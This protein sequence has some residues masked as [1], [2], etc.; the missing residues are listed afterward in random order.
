MSG[1]WQNV[2]TGNPI[3]SQL[4]ESRQTSLCLQYKSTTVTNTLAY[5]SAML[6]VIDGFLILKLH[7]E[8]PETMRKLCLSAKFL[9]EEVR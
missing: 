3:I 5:I 7:S 1:T 9:H 8:S 6:I 2:M 4:G